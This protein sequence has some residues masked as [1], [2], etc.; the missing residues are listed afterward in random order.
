MARLKWVDT[1]VPAAIDWPAAT[2]HVR[3]RLAEAAAA[4]CPLVLVEGFLLFACAP[5][6]A[7]LD[8]AVYLS[9]PADAA[10]RE[11]I[12]MR[13]YTRAHL[14]KKSYQ[15]RGITVDQYR[16]YVSLTQ[17]RPVTLYHII[18]ASLRPLLPN[19]PVTTLPSSSDAADRCCQQWNECVIE[20]FE[21][22]GERGRPEGTV[23]VP[24]TEETAAQVERLVGLLPIAPSL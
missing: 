7:L 11:E 22:H 2:A 24:C 6:V 9:L 5:I 19:S 1:N 23:E 10:G 18:C 16:R 3:Q 8:H 17:P 13:K 14:G 20:R 21:K 12:M 4:R 15:E